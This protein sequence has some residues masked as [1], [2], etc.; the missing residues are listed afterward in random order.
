MGSCKGCLAWGVLPRY[1]WTCWPCRWWQSHYP[2]GMCKYC[3]R[4]T[5]IGDQQA[6]RLCLEQARMLQIPGRATNLAA[7]T[8]HGQQL[9]LANMTR[10]RRKPPMP[11]LAPGRREPSPTQPL[12]GFDDR[13]AAQLTL[14]DAEPDP[15]AVRRRALAAND[16]LTRYC[17]AIV[18][19]HAQRHGWSNRQ[20]NAVIGSLRV[21]QATRPTPAAKIRASDIIGLRRYDGTVSSTIDVL[22]EADLLI[23]DVPTNVEKYFTGAFARPDG[24]P[25]VM[26]EHLQLWLQIMLGGSDQQPR[27]HPRDPQTV[28]LHILG[29]TPVITAWVESGRRSFAEI[30]ADD[31]TAA[32][33]QLPPDGS[34]RRIAEAGLKALFKVLK[35]RRLVF[36]DPTRALKTTPKPGNIPLPLDPAMIRAELNSTNPAVALAVALIAFHALTGKQLRELALTAIADGRMTVDG[37]NVPL[38]A[39]V[40]TRLAA[41][42]DHRARTW[43]GSIN[44]HLL[45]NR[46]TAPRLTT[47]GPGFPWVHTA[48][49][50]PRVLRE[51]RILHEIH[52]TGGDVRRICD[53]FGLQVA[54][55][56]RYLDTVEHPDLAIGGEQVRRT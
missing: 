1:N 20:R 22:T 43:P 18:T 37:R 19:E 46:R 45:I 13:A 29:M 3:H 54:A 27:Q 48:G 12:A 5:R 17:A 7:A 15:R 50:R 24:L 21:L 49:L 14:F 55:A 44:P 25:P 30:T 6:C 53:L 26:H 41:W 47:V 35:G 16:D 11:T 28:H 32:L 2:E 56:T 42:L 36:S 51:D 39:P 38:A 33:A 4:V 40:R 9:F 8:R 34:A 31:V 10:S 52:A 23:E